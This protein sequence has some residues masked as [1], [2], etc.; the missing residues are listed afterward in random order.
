[1]RWEYT[2][3]E[4]KLF[5]YDGKTLWIYE[6]DVPQIFKGTAN[7]DKL[8]KALAFLTG[9]GKI[10][11]SYK[12]ALAEGAGYGFKDGYVLILV[13]KEKNSPFKNVELYVNSTTYQVIRSVVIDHEGNR[14][15]L[16]F[17]NSLTNTNLPAKLFQFTPAAGVPVITAD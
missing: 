8:R 7:A 1:M 14:N 15:R 13:P 3:P 6:P 17:T 11:D 12:A 9:Q 4:K 2:R 16:D 10:K 5:V